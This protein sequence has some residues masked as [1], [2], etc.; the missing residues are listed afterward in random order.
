MVN[1]NLD[2]VFLEDVRIIADELSEFHDDLKGKTVLI[3]GGKGFLGTYFKNV[4]TKINETLSNPTKIIIMDSLITSK[5]KNDEKNPNVEF[6]EQ[7]ISQSLEIPINE[8]VYQNQYMYRCGTAQLGQ[9]WFGCPLGMING[10]KIRIFPQFPV[11][12]L[13]LVSCMKPACHHLH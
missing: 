5:E 4:L 2:N 10:S 13:S 6:V 3:A 8:T 7:D 12:C 1:K 11:W 9:C